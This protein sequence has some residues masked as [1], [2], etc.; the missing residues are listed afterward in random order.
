CACTTYFSTLSLHDA[1]PILIA[2][3]ILID[4]VTRLMVYGITGKEGQFHMLRNCAY[5]IHVVAGVTPGKGGQDVEGIP[6]FDTAAEAVDRS[7]EHTSELQSRV[8]LV[9]RL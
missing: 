9:C 6:V 7:E 4:E 1:L 5:G 8:E 3:A 2:V